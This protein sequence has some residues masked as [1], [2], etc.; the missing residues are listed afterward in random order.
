MRA[1]VRRVGVVAPQACVNHQS[2]AAQQAQSGWNGGAHSSVER[3]PVRST[4]LEVALPLTS[5]PPGDLLVVAD[6]L[7]YLACWFWGISQRRAGQRS[8]TLLCPGRSQ[9]CWI[10]PSFK[11]QVVFH[12]MKFLLINLKKNNSMTCETSS[13]WHLFSCYSLCVW[14]DF[15][16]PHSVWLET[17]SHVALFVSS[18][19]STPATLRRMH[20]LKDSTS[21]RCCI[22]SSEVNNIWSISVVPVFK[23]DRVS[24][25]GTVTHWIT[26]Y[27]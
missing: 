21:V 3:R 15:K 9:G 25:P 23:W 13:L 11:S 22:Y 19:H 4:P 2:G 5:P 27:N 16:V 26:G 1:L 12:K 17:V 18:R 24:G 7:P 10:R 8:H 14:D 20:V 6:F